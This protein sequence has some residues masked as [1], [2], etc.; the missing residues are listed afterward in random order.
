VVHVAE[1]RELDA[2]LFGEGGIGGGT[3]DADAED[4]RIRGIN[5]S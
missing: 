2:D 5:L 1:Q 3:V 4:F